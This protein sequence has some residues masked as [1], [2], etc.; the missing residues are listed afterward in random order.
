MKIY[1]LYYVEQEYIH[2]GYTDMDGFSD[3][4]YDQ[5]IDKEYTIGYFSNTQAMTKWINEHIKYG[6][7]FVDNKFICYDENLQ[8]EK[9]EVIE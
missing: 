6:G 2:S 4:Y 9:I 7:V 8:S 5:I 1:R 3:D